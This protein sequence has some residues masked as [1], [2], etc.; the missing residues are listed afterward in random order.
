MIPSLQQFFFNV[1]AIVEMEVLHRSYCLYVSDVLSFCAFEIIGDRCNDC[2]LRLGPSFVID[3]ECILR[4]CE[5]LGGTDLP[6]LN[7]PSQEVRIYF[8]LDLFPQIL[9]VSLTITTN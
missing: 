3:H 8:N 4:Y 9:F 6:I 2:S 1:Y 7:T 5:L